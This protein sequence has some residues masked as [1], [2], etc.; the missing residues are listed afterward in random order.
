[1]NSS[2]AL[3]Y[4]FGQHYRKGIFSL[5]DKKFNMHFY[6]GNKMSDVK[7]FDYK[8]LKGFKKQLNNVNI[9]K[10]IYYQTG[11]IKLVSKYD[12]FILLGEYYCISTWLFLVLAKIFKKEVYLWTHGWYGNEGFIKKTIKKTFFNLSNGLLLYGDYAKKLMLK[13]GFKEEKLHVIY[14]SLN[15]NTQ[16]KIRNTLVP[17]TIY[18]NYFKNSDPVIIFIGRL[19]KVK[20]LTQLIEAHEI[21]ENK[22][23]NF[24]VVF[25]GNGTEKNNLEA[26]ISEKNLNHKYWFY[27]SC[28][29]EKQIANLIFNA[30]ICVSPGNIGLTAMHALVYGTPVITNN[31]FSNQMPEFEAVK[32]G[33]NG[34][35]F[36]NNNIHDLSLKIT[37]WIELMKIKKQDVR[38]NCFKVIDDKFN[39]EYQYNIIKKALKCP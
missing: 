32:K 24:N 4:N 19:T 31:D 27:G 3:I 33:Y 35:F 7:S 16:L 20:K 10:G 6:F 23:I 28:Y 34:D 36:E 13:E 18:T 1:M 9:Y 2:I 30:D 22:N 39:P 12:K 8:S 14:N 25:V 5:L 29:D 21:A 26:L 37:N 11:T 15:Y 38:A 17:N